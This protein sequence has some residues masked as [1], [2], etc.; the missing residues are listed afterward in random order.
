MLKSPQQHHKCSEVSRPDKLKLDWESQHCIGKMMM[1]KRNSVLRFWAKRN[2]LK[3]ERALIFHYLS[4]QILSRI[5]LLFVISLS[6]DSKTD[7]R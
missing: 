3:T 4:N 1:Q 7:Q 6:S 2:E 5:T